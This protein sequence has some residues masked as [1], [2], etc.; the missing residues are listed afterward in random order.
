MKRNAWWNVLL[1]VPFIATLFPG[2]YN[3]LE[4]R[5]FGMPFF[6]WYQLVWTILAGVL[7]AIYIAVKR[8]GEN[9]G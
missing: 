8:G 9:A 2:L 3:A 6:Y 4:P 5:A 1:V 7:L